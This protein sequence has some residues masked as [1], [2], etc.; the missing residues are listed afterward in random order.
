MEILYDIFKFVHLLSIVTWVGMLIFF[1]F[2]AAPSIFKVLPRE[3]AGDVVGSIFP[4]YWL[5]GYLC[6]ALSIL[7]LGFYDGL[8]D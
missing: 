2:V 3:S 6:G 1:S 5:L 4:K 7:S 8:H